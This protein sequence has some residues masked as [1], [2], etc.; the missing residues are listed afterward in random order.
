MHS[1]HTRHG[2]RALLGLAAAGAIAAAAV[3]LPGASAGAASSGTVIAA[4]PGP[5]G[6]MLVVGSGR[7]AG[8]TL[9][10]ITSDHGTSFG[11]TTRPVASNHGPEICTGPSNDS[12]AEWPA[13][14]TTG[15]PVAGPGVRQSL[16]GVVHRAGIG[17]QVT[18]AGHPLYLFDSMPGSV[19]GEAWDEPNLPPWHGV[20]WLVSPQGTAQP[21]PGELTTIQIHGHGVLAAVFYTGLGLT[22]VPVYA[23]SAD[24]GGSSACTGACAIAWPPVLTS[25]TPGVQ[26]VLRSRVGTIARSDGTRQ[27]TYEGRP[28][29]LFAFEQPV[30]GPHGIELVGN[31]NGLTVGSGSFH[32]IGT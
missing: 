6:T 27:I 13:I 2:R 24:G 20:W 1:H 21:W 7:Y 16:L 32:L 8:Y 29:Y 10:Y 5:F 18:Y 26:G 23:Y 28:L 12:H 14:T 15:A 11:C 19:T 17:M 4:A 9:Y 31:G 30:R 25:G 3:A 22:P